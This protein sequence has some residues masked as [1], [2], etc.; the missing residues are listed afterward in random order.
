MLT[1]DY[2]RRGTAVGSGAHEGDKNITLA[3]TECGVWWE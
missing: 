2:G 1:G 3:L